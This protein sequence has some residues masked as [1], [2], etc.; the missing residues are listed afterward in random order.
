MAVAGVAAVVPAAGGPAPVLSAAPGGPVTLQR[1]S[2][3]E[4]AA[5]VHRALF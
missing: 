1:G 2:G 3:L 5:A 4:T